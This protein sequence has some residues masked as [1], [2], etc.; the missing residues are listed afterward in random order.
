MTQYTYGAI[1]DMDRHESNETYRSSEALSPKGGIQ[2]GRL[3]LR[4]VAEIAII[5]TRLDLDEKER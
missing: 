3:A 1:G 2:P 5:M 4:C